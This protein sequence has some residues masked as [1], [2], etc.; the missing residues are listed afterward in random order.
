MVSSDPYAPLKKSGIHVSIN[1]FLL[2]DKPPLLGVDKFRIRLNRIDQLVGIGNR[3][4]VSVVNRYKYFSITQNNHTNVRNST[5]GSD[6][7]SGLD[8]I[9]IFIH[10][11]DIGI[12][13]L[14][15]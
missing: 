10:Q 7:T 4:F 8:K 14:D 5:D 9:C 11:D 3:A 6:K 15:R 2:L 12:H 13:S 1:D